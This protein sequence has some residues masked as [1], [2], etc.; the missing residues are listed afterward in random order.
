M[1]VINH[2][3]HLFDVGTAGAYIALG[4]LGIVALFVIFQALICFGRGTSRSIMRLITIGAA[5]VCAFF[6]ACILGRAILPEKTLSSI[7]PFEVGVLQPILDASLSQVL[8]PLFFLALFFLF[9]WILLLP[10]KLLCGIL[11]FSHKR[12]NIVTRLGGIVVGIVHGAVTA[13]VVLL[14]IFS[15]MGHYANAEHMN[16][17]ATTFYEDY[18]EDT[19]ESPLYEY[20]MQYGGDYIL[21]EFAKANKSNLHG[22]K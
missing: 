2:Y 12:N 13:M 10:H 18:V 7:I 4:A 17:V 11:G 19:V 5:A 1:S 20:P 9:S 6:G 16:S 15:L 3:K 14:P 21:D 22:K 8:V